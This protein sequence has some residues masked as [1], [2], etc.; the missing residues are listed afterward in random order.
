[1][2][3]RVFK[4]FRLGL[5]FCCWAVA[6]S[7]DLNLTSHTGQTVY[8]SSAVATLTAGGSFTV[9]S[10]DTVTLHASQSIILKNGFVARVGSNFLARLIPQLPETRASASSAEVIGTTTTLSAG[11]TKVNDP[12]VIFTWQVVGYVPAPVTFSLNGSHAAH[13]TVATFT[14]A[15][16][17]LFRV[18]DGSPQTAGSTDGL[19]YVVVSVHQERNRI[20]V[21]PN[22]VTMVGTQTFTATVVDQFSH[23]MELK[24]QTFN[25]S[26]SGGNSI[27]PDGVFSGNVGSSTVTCSVGGLAGSASVTVADHTKVTQVWIEK[28]ADPYDEPAIGAAVHKPV[29]RLFVKNP[30]W[31]KGNRRT[32]IEFI[33]R[34][35][36]QLGNLDRSQT[37]ALP[38]RGLPSRHGS[39]KVRRHDR[40][41]PQSDCLDIADDGA[42]DFSKRPITR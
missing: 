9:P 11:G 6:L 3:A 33:N 34:K 22:S 31:S 20:V 12:S 26:A 8:G 37:N 7:Q 38:S 24:D 29:F 27:S 5:L 10:A 41:S 25:W 13:T 4:G 1:M 42:R 2:L 36:L 30:P 18:S 28:L 17:Y 40:S 32:G 21:S 15:G 19:N 39:K 16:K 14:K 35:T 23:P